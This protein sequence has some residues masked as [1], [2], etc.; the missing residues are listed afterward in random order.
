MTAVQPFLNVIIRSGNLVKAFF[1]CRDGHDL[2]EVGRDNHH[3]GSKTIAY[4]CSRCHRYG[5]QLT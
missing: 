2:Q 5:E 3:D 4:E 1:A